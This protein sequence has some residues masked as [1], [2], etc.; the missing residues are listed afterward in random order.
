MFFLTL[1]YRD[2][3]STKLKIWEFASLFKS[4]FNGH[5]PPF[6][7]VEVEERRNIYKILKEKPKR[8]KQLG[9]TL[10]C[11]DNIEVDLKV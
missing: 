2:A 5:G 11:D 10:R 8:K 9:K 1:S 3:Q 6:C 4:V 7:S